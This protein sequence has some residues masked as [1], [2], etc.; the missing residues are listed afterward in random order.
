MSDLSVEG[1]RVRYG[2]GRRE[3]LAV[4]DV[5]L[6]VPSGS[7]MG[8]VGESGCGK[9]SLARVVAGI[10][11]REAGRVLI[12]GTPLGQHDR[13]VQMVF[14]NP[15]SSLNPAMTAVG[16]VREAIDPRLR[17]RRP[18]VE[19]E[20]RALLEL[21]G[22]DPSLGDRYPRQLSGGQRQRVAIARALA[23]KPLV[24]LADEIT[25]ALDVSVQ[26]TI[27]NLLS[28]LQKR[29]S[30]TMLFISHNLAAVRYACDSVA[31]MQ[32]GQIVEVGP[33]EQV[34]REPEHDY[35]AHLLAAIPPSIHA[36]RPRTEEPHAHR[37]HL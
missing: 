10:G 19:E 13:R 17:N 4:R 15:L 31:V 23:A 20:A 6:F 32:G 12:D 2:R 8:L 3:H 33:V 25:S 9:T 5:D 36:A 18:A 14:Q 11:Q 21:V 34:T 29:L 16:S 28:N 26:A 1:V 27:L 22:L 24:L 30:L 37:P 7:A 35:T